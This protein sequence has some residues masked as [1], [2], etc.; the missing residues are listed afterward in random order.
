MFEKGVERGEPSK[1]LRKWIRTNLCT[2]RR[3]TLVTARRGNSQLLFFS[4]SED[5]VGGIHCELPKTKGERGDG[6]PLDR[7]LTRGR[8]DKEEM[9]IFPVGFVN[10]DEVP[11]VNG[12]VISLDGQFL[13]QL[14]SCNFCPPSI[15]P[16]ALMLFV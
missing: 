12:S 3:Q 15:G 1:R 7:L 16:F 8:W 5:T 9:N 4:N 14:V 11:A 10:S 13:G 2:I 6:P